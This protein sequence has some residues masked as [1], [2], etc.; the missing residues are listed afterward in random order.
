MPHCETDCCSPPLCSRLAMTVSTKQHV[1]CTPASPFRSLTPRTRLARPPILDLRILRHPHALQMVPS[2]LATTTVLR[3]LDHLRRSI[4][5]PFAGRSSEQTHIPL[6]N[7]LRKPTNAPPL[8]L[9]MQ[10]NLISP[11]PLHQ[12]RKNAPSPSYSQPPST[13]SPSTPPQ[14]STPPPPS[15][16]THSSPNSS[17]APIPPSP[18]LSS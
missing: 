3:A 1:L 10:E 14:S 12:E 6:L 11:H 8:L 18:A 9:L 7:R 17:S 2:H 16:S 15:Q 13:P 4:S 5:T